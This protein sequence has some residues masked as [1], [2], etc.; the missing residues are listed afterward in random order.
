MAACQSSSGFFHF[1]RPLAARPPAIAAGMKKR[2][3]PGPAAS[4]DAEDV[5]KRL[6]ASLD[7]FER[8][9]H[10]EHARVAAF[11]ARMP[12]AIA[13]MSAADADLV[14]FQLRAELV[15]TGSAAPAKPVFRDVLLQGSASLFMLA[16][17]L[18]AVFSWTPPPEFVYKPVGGRLP[19]DFA[20]C[21]SAA[22]TPMP[23]LRTA[24]A[25]KAVSIA[26][27]WAKA[28]STVRFCTQLGHAYKVW[29]VGGAPR[30]KLRGS[31]ECLPRCVGGQ[32]LAPS[33][34]SL[35]ESSDPAPFPFCEPGFGETMEDFYFLNGFLRGS[36]QGPTGLFADDTSQA[37]VEEVL[38]RT[39]AEPPFF[40]AV[41]GSGSVACNPECI[42]FSDLRMGVVKCLR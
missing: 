37:E 39:V 14:V 16:K 15:Q 36:R 25:Q 2:V 19:P 12:A 10:E 30:E 11:F 5:S 6:K 23:E 32:G 40:V 28:L 8:E 13:A 33:D 38:N 35:Q 34:C 27:I 17:T 41:D 31:Y 1:T 7:R 20:W 18:G 3:A 42:E 26:S 29:C 4:E 22:G 24:A 21:A 9:E